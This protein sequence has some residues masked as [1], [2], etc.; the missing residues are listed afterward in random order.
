MTSTLASYSLQ[1]QAI[2]HDFANIDFAQSE[3]TSYVNQARTR[4]ALDTHCVRQ[5]FTNLQFITNVEQYPLGGGTGGVNILFSGTGYVAPVVQ[6]IGGT[7]S[8]PAIAA[9]TQSQGQIQQIVMNSWGQGYQSQPYVNIYDP[10]AGGGVSQWQLRQAIAGAGYQVS[11]VNSA[12]PQP[13]SVTLATAQWQSCAGSA[14]GDPVSQTVQSSLGLSS[15][16]TSLIYS[17][18]ASLPQ[19]QGVAPYVTA[20]QLR[21]ALQNL[22]VLGNVA[23]GVT[24]NANSPVNMQWYSGAPSGNGDPLSVF[25]APYLPT[26]TALGTFY[27]Y[28]ATM[29]NPYVTITNFQLRQALFN[30]GYLNQAQQAVP[31]LATDAINMIWNTGQGTAQPTALGVSPGPPGVSNQFIGTGFNQPY[32]GPSGDLMFNF[33]QAILGANGQS[34]LTL[35]SNASA[36]A[37][38][39]GGMNALATAV[40]MSNVLDWNSVSVIWGATKWVLDW[41]PWTMFQAYCRS[42]MWQY[43]YPAAWSQILEQNMAKAYPIPDQPYSCEID[44]IIQPDPLVNQSDVDYQVTPPYDDLPQFYAAHLAY[45][46]LQNAPMM[47]DYEA[48]Y[49]RRLIEIVGTR[50]GRRIMSTYH[51]AFRRISR[52]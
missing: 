29:N 12:F 14:Y 50:Y 2:L 7:P 13:P 20:Y 10:V 21:Q 18:A 6:F 19:V 33:A 40:T 24:A 3:I 38:G 17:Q 35:Y 44:A 5:L 52:L 36:L 48:K 1:L 8:I 27:A 32:P 45:Q 42:W 4:T 51:N 34:A 41:M 49:K 28:A 15:A 30:L 31:A 43:R 16:Q 9:A 23:A 25:I 47:Q 37:S 11:T 26:G 39:P 22:G 46:K